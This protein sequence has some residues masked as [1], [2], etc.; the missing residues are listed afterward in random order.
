[1]RASE[2]CK[3]ITLSS[4]YGQLFPFLIFATLHFFGAYLRNCK[5]ES[6]ET[7]YIERWQSEIVQSARTVTLLKV[8]TELLP[9]LIFAIISLSIAYLL[10]YFTLSLT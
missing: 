1:M 9:V 6:N 2:V 5:R 10:N 7:Q 4:V 3:N 8:I